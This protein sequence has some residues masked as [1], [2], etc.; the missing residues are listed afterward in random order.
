M[1]LIRWR[2]M[3]ALRAH[4]RKSSWAAAGKYK[5]NPDDAIMKRGYADECVYLPSSLYLC[6]IHSWPLAP[7]SCS[8]ESVC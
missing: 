8:A 7:P 1:L 4:R 2:R 3:R 6:G 5:W